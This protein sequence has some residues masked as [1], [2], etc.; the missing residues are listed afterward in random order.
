MKKKDSVKELS[1]AKKPE[2]EDSPDQVKQE[3]NS[4]Y[5]NAFD[6]EPNRTELK[7]NKENSRYDHE[8]EEE[9]RVELKQQTDLNKVEKKDEEEE[10]ENDGVIDGEVDGEQERM[11]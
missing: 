9:E 7:A 8:E 1:T 5:E 6:D 10:D 4:D 2:I 3:E 11:L